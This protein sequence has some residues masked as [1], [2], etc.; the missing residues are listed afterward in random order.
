V[1]V[2]AGVLYWRGDRTTPDEPGEGRR[3]SNPFELKSALAFGALYAVIL[4]GAKAA[5]MYLGTA[6]VYASALASGLA[7]V[8]AVPLTMAELSARGG[9]D[10]DTARHAVVLAAASNTVVKGGMVLA[11]GAPAMRRA[12]VPGL[13]LVLAAMLSVGFLL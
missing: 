9:L 12:L 2:W 7:N 3:F 10:L 8:D 1:L 4:V 6:G 5:E 13:A 11:L